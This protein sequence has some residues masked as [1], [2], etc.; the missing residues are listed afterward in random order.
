MS[1]FQAELLSLKNILDNVNERNNKIMKNGKCLIL[2]DE[3]LKGTQPEEEYAL[4]MAA[5]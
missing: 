3:I 5:V 4:S 2:M 1:H